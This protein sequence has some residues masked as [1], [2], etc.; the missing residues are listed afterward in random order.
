MSFYINSIKNNYS[1]GIS[2]IVSP[3]W[4]SKSCAKCAK[5]QKS[6]EQLGHF[7]IKSDFETFTTKH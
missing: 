2:K 3:D 5:Y 6:I 4:H 1:L 7:Q